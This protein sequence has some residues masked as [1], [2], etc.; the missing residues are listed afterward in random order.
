MRAEGN[1]MEKKQAE[2]KRELTLEESFDR[3]EA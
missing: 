3:L 1:H 2:T